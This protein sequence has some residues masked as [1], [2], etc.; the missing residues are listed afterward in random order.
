MEKVKDFEISK[1][2]SADQLVRQMRESGGFT[3]KHLAVGV[4]ILEEML[5]DRNC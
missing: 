2:L 5:K 4:D 3:A 1:G